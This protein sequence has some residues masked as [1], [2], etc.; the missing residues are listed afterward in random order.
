MFDSLA[1]LGSGLIGTSVLL[2][3]KSRG[4]VRRASVWDIDPAHAAA[5]AG[6]AGADRVAVDA[7]EAVRDADIVVIA[8]PSDTVADLVARVAPSLKPGALVTDGASVKGHIARVAHAAM[9]ENAF[10]VGAHPMAGSEKNGPAA[11]RADLFEG[12]SC[13]VTPLSGR[14]DDV[15]V[16]KVAAFW[17]ALGASTVLVSPDDHDEIV[18]HI[19]H[20]PHAVAVALGAQLAGKP[21]L[22]RDC[23]GGGLRDTTRIAGGDPEIWRAILM[24]NRHDVARALAAFE[25]ELR[26]LRECLE[27]SDVRGLVARLERAREWRAGLV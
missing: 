26:A 10:F 27:G 21:D 25:D 3:A 4:V 16:A 8:T 13:F 15:A 17:A 24:E 14:S 22:W 1:I 6:P 19:S 9:P 2:A 7:A 12:R 23:A 5:K 20:L 18:A 11:A